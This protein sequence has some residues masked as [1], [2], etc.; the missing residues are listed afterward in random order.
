[1]ADV[2]GV[3][4]VVPPAVALVSGR[5]VNLCYSIFTERER[6]TTNVNVEDWEGMA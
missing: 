6:L 3:K 1:M 4:T 5:R 2:W